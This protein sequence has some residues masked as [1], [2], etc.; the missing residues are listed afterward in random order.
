MELIIW[1][2]VLAAAVLIIYAL[3]QWMGISIDPIVMRIAS[4]LVVAIFLVVIVRFL[5]PFLVGGS[6]PSLR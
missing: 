2:I 6:L 1:L 5:W 4:I 3:I